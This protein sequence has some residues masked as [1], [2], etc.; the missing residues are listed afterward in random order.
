M[1][2]RKRA[3]N[4]KTAISTKK[5]PVGKFM[6]ARLNPDGTVSFKVPRKRAAKKRTKKNGA[7]QPTL[8]NYWHIRSTTAGWELYNSKTKESRLYKSHASAEA[9]WNRKASARRKR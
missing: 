8:R 4:P 7:K 3:M 5:I 1:A 6:P 9:A 2:K